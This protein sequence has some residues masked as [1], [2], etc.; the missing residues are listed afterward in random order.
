MKKL[1]EI[2]FD[3]LEGTIITGF[4]ISIVLS[5]IVVLIIAIVATIQFLTITFNEWFL[6]V[7]LFA[8]VGISLFLLFFILGSIGK[9]FLYIWK[10]YTDKSETKKYKKKN[11]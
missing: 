9:F 8:G 5:I 1:F 6:S 7:I 2:L 3:D 11:I 10:K 4:G